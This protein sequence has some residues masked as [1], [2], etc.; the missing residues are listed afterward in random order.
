MLDFL[1]LKP[2]LEHNVQL[3]KSL[4]DGAKAKLTY[5]KGTLQCLMIKD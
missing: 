2:I 5:M 1:N 3:A 4:T